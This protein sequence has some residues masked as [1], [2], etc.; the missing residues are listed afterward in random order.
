MF[1]PPESFVER[2]NSEFRGRLR[3]RWSLERGEWHIEQKVRRGIFPGERPTNDKRGWDETSDSYIRHRDGVVLVVA[4]RTGDRMPCPRCHS[5]L[6][7]PFM[8][9]NVVTCGLC[10][11]RGKQSH[12]PVMFVPLNDDLINYLKKIDPENPISEGLAE[13]LDQQNE[14]YAQVM[15]QDAVNQGV[16][17]FEQDYRRVVGIPRVGLTGSTK[18]WTKD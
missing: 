6:K 3:L 4:V 18:M 10:K 9:T 11:I 17:A 16:A 2:L 7:V 5:E 13:Q 12:W 1:H 14:L 8:V 15:E